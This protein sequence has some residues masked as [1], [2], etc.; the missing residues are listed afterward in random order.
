[1]NIAALVSGGVDSSVVVHQLKEAGHDPTIFYIRIGMEDKDGYIDCPSEEDIEMT[2]FIAKKYGCRFEI[3][4]LHEE[5]WENVV[6]YTINAVKKG[7]TP[8]PDMMCN[9]LIKFGCFERKWGK[10]FDKIATGHYAT[11]TLVD[12]KTYL[13]TAAD[14]VKDQTYFLGQIDSLQLSKLIFPI[15]HLP[16]SEVRRI[17]A[18]EGLPSA[19]RKDSQGICFLGKINYNDFIRRYLGEKPGEIIELETGKIIGQH[20]GY[21]FHTIGQRKGIGLSGGPWFVVRKDSRQ[22]ILYV[23]NGYDPET[24]YGTTVNLQ[25][26]RFITENPWGN[27]TGKQPITFKI[28][29]TPEF[30]TGTLQRIGEIY[31]I[32]SDEKIQ[33]IAAGQFGVVYDRQQRLCLGSGV[34]VEN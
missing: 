15:G 18:R 21:W 23:S 1:M 24:Q 16:K 17:A 31:R 13:S 4:S 29:H 2:S 22:N 26:F 11:T 3:V 20:R 5:Y 30:T 32:A 8:N 19:Q 34:I 12:G 33:G 10:D 14:K 9:K 7:L 27:F 25:D 6:S 28:R